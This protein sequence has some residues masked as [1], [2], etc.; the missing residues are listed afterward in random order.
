MNKLALIDELIAMNKTGE[1]KFEEPK[2]DVENMLREIRKSVWTDLQREIERD[3]TGI[4]TGYF[5]PE[6]DS[7]K[8]F[9]NYCNGNED[10]EQALDSFSDS[11]LEILWQNSHI[12]ETL[13]EMQIKTEMVKLIGQLKIL[14]VAGRT[15]TAGAEKRLKTMEAIEARILGLYNILYEGE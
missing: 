8:Q 9:L 4:H 7:W 2:K 14:D 1:I 3:V 6:F 15:S 5:A 13:D 10:Y 11:Q 12:V